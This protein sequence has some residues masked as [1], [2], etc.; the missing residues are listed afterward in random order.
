MEFNTAF[1][2]L[3]ETTKE[4]VAFVKLNENALYL[5]VGANEIGME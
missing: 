5:V 1:W 4:D 3:N 2:L